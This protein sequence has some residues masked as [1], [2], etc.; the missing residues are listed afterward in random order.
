[1][2]SSNV[3]IVWI[4]SLGCVKHSLQSSCFFGKTNHKLDPISLESNGYGFPEYYTVDG[5]KL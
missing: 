1:M 2:S 4:Y 3:Y 5:L